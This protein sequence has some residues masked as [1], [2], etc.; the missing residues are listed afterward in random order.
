MTTEDLLADAY[1]HLLRQTDA[2]AA[3]ARAAE[4][5]DTAAMNRHL[6]QAARSAM[7]CSKLLIASTGLKGLSVPKGSALH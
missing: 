7:A 1:V 5:A 3:A 4:A 2:L 6:Q